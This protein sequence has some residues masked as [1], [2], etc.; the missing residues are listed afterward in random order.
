[1]ENI[2]KNKLLSIAFLL[3]LSSTANASI[4]LGFG[5]AI[6]TGGTVNV[7]V[8][9]SG[10]GSGSTPSLYD[11]S[12]DIDFNSSYLSFS[13]AVFGDATLGNQLDLFDFGLNSSGVSVDASGV[14]NIYEFSFDEVADLN[15]DQAD[16]FTL[17]TLSFNILQHGNSQLSFI[18]YDLGDTNLDEFGIGNLL[19]ATTLGTRTVSTVPVPAAFWLM[20]SGLGLL[21]RQKK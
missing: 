1:M 4:S 17:A 15:A 21:Y 20:V 18:G 2:K 3:L 9:I 19:T 8:T 6:Q 14:L 10:L 7:D 12:L 5:T 16:S 11:Y 13:G